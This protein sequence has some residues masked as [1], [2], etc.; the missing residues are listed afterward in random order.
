MAT[1]LQDNF[2]RVD[3]NSVL[4]SPQVGPAPT[5]AV[6]TMG[7]STNRAYASAVPGMVTWALGTADVELSVQCTV[8]TSANA[9]SIILGY[10]SATDYY[11]IQALTT[12]VTLFKMSTGGAA[13]LAI[14]TVKLP[15]SGTSVLRA[16]YKD[17]IIRAY[18]D[19]VLAIR[20]VVD[21]PITATAHGL[22]F[23]NNAAVRADNLL[24]TDAPTVSE[25]VLT[26]GTVSAAFTGAAVPT[27][28]SPSFAYL[29]RDTKLQDIAEGA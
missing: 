7:I 23:T 18:V 19:D 20:F 10:A 14:S 12:S 8:I 1:L 13:Q 2:D 22:R 17:G 21:V 28:N 25:P 26:G 24:G 3:N 6:G 5:V 27:F 29:G 9:L 4:G 11:Q 16:H 15:V